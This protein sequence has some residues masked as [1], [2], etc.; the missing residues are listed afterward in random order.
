[1]TEQGLD[2]QDHILG[3]AIQIISRMQGQVNSSLSFHSPARQVLPT[4]LS[5]EEI[6]V[7]E[8]LPE[9]EEAQ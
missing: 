8:S 4:P 6:E 5:Q 3:N 2:R 9:D 7:A 1:V